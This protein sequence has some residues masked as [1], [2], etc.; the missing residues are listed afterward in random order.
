VSGRINADLVEHPSTGLILNFARADFGGPQQAAVVEDWRARRAAGRNRRLANPGEFI[1]HY[2]RDHQNPSMYLHMDEDTGVIA[3]SHWPG[4]G[5][6]AHTIVHDVVTPEHRRQVEYMQNAGEAAGLRVEVEKYLS[7][8]VK[9][10]AIVY[11]PQADMGVEVQRSRLSVPAARSRT[12]KA[13]V[14]GVTSVWFTDSHFNPKW[15]GHVPGVRLNPDIPWNTVP[16][17]RSVS[18]AG[19]RHIVERN[20]RTWPGSPCPRHSRGCSAWH[21]DH[22]PQRGVFADDLVELVP[23]GQMVPM[24]FKTF[25]GRKLALIVFAESKA[26]YEAMVGHS[27]DLT[28][29]PGSPRPAGARQQTQIDCTSGNAGP[30]I[31]RTRHEPNNQGL[32][33]LTPAQQQTAS[34]LPWY[35]QWLLQNGY[36]EDDLIPFVVA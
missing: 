3:A 31:A 12:T 32:L 35:R 30:L 14:A 28:L 7:T 27:A 5:L 34:E 29:V 8:K 2:H 6:E 25:S 11:G 19:V 15:I 23:I 18:V 16:H 10:D 24:E 9:P 36:T 13:L 26:R 4:S 1:C 20:C 17:R 22:V 33:A 21:P